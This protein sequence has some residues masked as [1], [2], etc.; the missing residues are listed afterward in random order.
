MH[1]PGASLL[2]NCPM[3][4]PESHKPN[5]VSLFLAAAVCP[6]GKNP[7]VS[8]KVSGAA[9]SH[10]EPLRAGSGAVGEGQSP[11]SLEGCCPGGLLCRRSTERGLGWGAVASDQRPGLGGLRP[12]CPEQSPRP[13]SSLLPG[14][15]CLPGRRPQTLLRAPASPLRGA[16]Q[17]QVAAD[18]QP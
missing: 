9:R 7:S 17:A 15:L 3:Q 12:H 2:P 8:V 16:Q 11:L 6:V 4:R 1:V 13:V 18:A 10:P 5:P 14:V